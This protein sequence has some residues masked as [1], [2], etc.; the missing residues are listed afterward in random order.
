MRV[1]GGGPIQ[2]V[3]GI[4]MPTS[5]TL[6]ECEIVARFVFGGRDI[7]DRFEEPAR[8]EPIH[9]RECRKLHGLQMAPG[10]LALNE[11]GLEKADDGFGER[12]VIVM[13]LVMTDQPGQQAVLA[14]VGSY[15]GFHG[16]R[17]ETAV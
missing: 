4:Q 14:Q 11:L 3:V 5:T 6:C 8:V 7:A 15:D 2:R 10:S 9:P 16:A 13:I 1:L 17:A 12:V